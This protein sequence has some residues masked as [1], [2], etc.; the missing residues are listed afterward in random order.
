[1]CRLSFGLTLL[2]APLVAAQDPSPDRDA[3]LRT[4][5]AAE[6]SARLDARPAMSRLRARIAARDKAVSEMEKALHGKTVTLDFDEA[7]FEDVRIRL[8]EAAGFVLYNHLVPQSVYGPPVTVHLKEVSLREALESVLRQV[9]LD[10]TYDRQYLVLVPSLE[11]D[12]VPMRELR[13]DV[14]V[15]LGSGPGDAS[16]RDNNRVRKKLDERIVLETK[17]W[18]L[19]DALTRVG[20]MAGIR[21][22]IAPESTE[23]LGGIRA[24]MGGDMPLWEFLSWIG[25]PLG[26]GFAIRGG[27]LLAIAYE[28]MAVLT[29]NEARSSSAASK[30]IDSIGVFSGFEEFR[31]RMTGVV[32]VKIPAGEFEMGSP[33]DEP[34]RH[35]SEARR[36]VR[37]ERPFFLSKSEVTNLQFSRFAAR[38]TY[39]PSHASGDLGD[40]VLEA[41]QQPVVRVSWLDVYGFCKWSGLRLPTEEEWEYV[42]R[43]GDGRA[44]PWGNAWPPPLGAA[45]LA[46]TC[47]AREP[48]ELG[49]P[50]IPGYLDNG[51]ATTAV[52][53][54][55]ANRFGIVDMGGNVLEWCSARF[56]PEE[57]GVDPP[58][59]LEVFRTTVPVLRGGGWTDSRPSLL[60]CAA[61][62]SAGPDDLSPAVGF[63]V[64]IDCPPEP[65]P[66]D[67]SESAQ[68]G[69]VVL[70]DLLEVVSNQLRMRILYDSDIPGRRVRALPP[71]DVKREDLLSMLLARLGEQG[72]TLVKVGP[73]GAE[74]WKVLRLA[75]RVPPRDPGEVTIVGLEDLAGL[76][77]GATSA[78]LV[79]RLQY[80]DAQTAALAVRGIVEDPSSLHAIQEAGLLVVVGAADAL[81]RVGEILRSVDIPHAAQG[82]ESLMVETA[83][84]EVSSAALTARGIRVPGSDEEKALVQA[85]AD[86]LWASLEEAV[87]SDGVRVLHRWSGRI[88]MGVPIRTGVR[89]G[90]FAVRLS[91]LPRLP[92]RS[93]E[94]GPEGEESREDPAPGAGGGEVPLDV[95]LQITLGGG[96]SEDRTELAGKV[97]SWSVW[98][99]PSAAHD[100]VRRLFFVRTGR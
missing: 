99:P 97:G 77:D 35:A 95:G 51:T 80:I 81:R 53:D 24:E 18:L 30:E 34:G 83:L 78:R 27:A 28:D 6:E 52:G 40:L 38:R 19:T 45:N 57:P 8:Q 65:T 23:R 86:A 91:L 26:V 11:T 1:M 69:G 71:G 74:V 85:D 89:A 39:L 37:I 49:L 25:P 31:D 90:A 14:F 46:D 36:R 63:R 93:A 22:E 29:A 12:F 82:D 43:C 17:P 10:Y 5:A 33:E 68:E 72:L 62:R 13:R 15:S 75:R 94:Q 48:L 59:P 3:F 47:V 7:S 88:L 44:F 84:F 42:A 100:G 70:A 92:N 58:D 4:L 98:A 96:E 61:R 55:S 56:P 87:G 64:A 50:S 60:R 76:P 41:A 2:L 9:G 79:V 21:V 20:E 16:E 67:E 73:A 66:A 32:F 54:S